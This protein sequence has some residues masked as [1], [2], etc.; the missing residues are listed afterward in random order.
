MISSSLERI[1]LLD[2]NQHIHQGSTIELRDVVNRAHGDV[3]SFLYI[4][5]SPLFGGEIALGP[6]RL[7][8]NENSPQESMA[9]LQYALNKPWPLSYDD[10]LKLYT[11]AYRFGYMFRLT[12]VEQTVRIL[13]G[14][15]KSELIARETASKA[16]S[17]LLKYLTNWERRAIPAYTQ[18]VNFLKDSPDLK[19]SKREFQVLVSNAV[20]KA[21]ATHPVEGI[22]DVMKDVSTLLSR[23]PEWFDRFSKTEFLA[24]LSD[25]GL[26]NFNGAVVVE[27]GLY[28]EELPMEQW[29]LA[30]RRF[31]RMNRDQL[32]SRSEEV[33]HLTQE[34]LVGFTSFLE[35]L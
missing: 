16:I 8:M 11:D 21:Y 23:D 5:F 27:A 3:R 34:E 35:N 29:V 7:K 22:A 26:A 1:A 9:Q 31:D 28:G 18:A 10:V 14:W 25:R 20:E 13:Y 30:I 33:E 15:R 2:V 12:P 17:V 4:L 24:M 6:V 19:V 32:L